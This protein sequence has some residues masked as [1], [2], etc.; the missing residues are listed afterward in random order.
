MVLEE[1][2]KEFYDA[3]KEKVGE[4][5]TDDQIRGIVEKFDLE[6]G[7]IP[8]IVITANPKEFENKTRIYNYRGATQE[9]GDASTKI[10]VLIGDYAPGIDDIYEDN[11][12]IPTETHE[13]SDFSIGQI[14]VAVVIA[15]NTGRYAD[16]EHSEAI[17]IYIPDEKEYPENVSFKQMV[18]EERKKEFYDAIK[19][20][21]GETLTDDQIR[22]IVEKFDLEDGKIPQIVITANPKEFEN[23]TRIYNYRGATQ[24][25]GDAS[26]KIDVLIGDYAPGIDDIYE[27]NSGIPTETHE[28]SDFSIGQIQVA[29]VIAE[30]TGRYADEEHSE[31]IHIYIPDEKEYPENVSFRQM[32]LENGKSELERREEQLT[33]LEGV[34]RQINK[35]EALIN[36][37]NKNKGQGIG[38]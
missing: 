2:K 32:M 1:R 26:T 15:E 35:A 8:Q 25:R 18:L 5:L 22:G 17:H 9:R 30:N 24:E 38:E 23:K 36:E 20:K 14:Q 12:G 3:I 34:E 33:A 28:M 27:D 31:A 29:V 21:V 4:T 16:E 6:D 13:M 37:Q 11:S 19:E 10:D 7:K